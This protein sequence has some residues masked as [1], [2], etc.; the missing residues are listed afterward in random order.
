M[1]RQEMTIVPLQGMVIMGG[2][3]LVLNDTGLAPARERH[4]RVSHTATTLV[5]PRDRARGNVV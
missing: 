2:N 4:R 3:D 5:V 1:R